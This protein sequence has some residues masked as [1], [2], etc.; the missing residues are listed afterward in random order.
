MQSKNNKLVNLDI[1]ECVNI[2]GGDA[3]TYDLGFSLGQISNWIWEAATIFDGSQWH[4]R[5]SR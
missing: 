5:A 4:T 1:T 2:S 3:F